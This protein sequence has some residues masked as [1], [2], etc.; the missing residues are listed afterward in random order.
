MHV[1][2]V[3]LG[4]RQLNDEIDGWDV[5]SSGGDVGGDETLD[6]SVSERLEG[7]FSLSLGDVSVED[8]TLEFEVSVEQDFVC[9]S[10]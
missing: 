6:A 5:E 2:V 4:R 10:F 7:D 9:F 3:V 1:R 8:L